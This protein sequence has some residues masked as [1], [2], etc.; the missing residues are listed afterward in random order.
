MQ[1]TD[2][3]GFEVHDFAGNVQAGADQRP[4]VAFARDQEVVQ[5]RQRRR[6]A[7]P[8]EQAG[9]D[10]LIGP[11]FR[12]YAQAQSLYQQLGDDGPAVAV[13][14]P[15]DGGVDGLERLFDDEGG[16]AGGR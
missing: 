14:A 2:V 13:Q 16:A 1:E 10:E 4:Q 7:Q 11:R 8:Y 6:A 9:L 12:Q 5:R 3:G 15:G